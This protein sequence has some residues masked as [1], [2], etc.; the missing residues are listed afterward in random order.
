M[1]EGDTLHRIAARVGPVLSGGTVTRLA[2]ADLGDVREAHG[3]TVTGVEAIGKH[4][5]VSFDAGWTLRTHLGMHGRVFTARPGRPLP[6]HPTFVVSVAWTGGSSPE[7]G[8][9]PQR[10]MGVTSPYGSLVDSPCG[11]KNPVLTW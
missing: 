11:S 7:V 4:L 2:L 9:I 3:W 6:R 10:V 1:P 8:G 5:L